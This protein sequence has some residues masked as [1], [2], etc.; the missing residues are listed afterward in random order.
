MQ[1]LFDVATN[2][3][4][5]VAYASTLAGDFNGDGAVDAADYVI[6]RKGAGDRYTLADFNVWRAHFGQSSGSGSA[7]GLSAPEPPCAWLL[8]AAVPALP[9][10]RCRVPR[11]TTTRQRALRRKAS[12][13]L[14]RLIL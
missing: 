2:Q 6:W 8:L 10:L 7:V 4:L 9:Y 11:D 1:Y 3:Y 5:T 13:T 12:R 14:E